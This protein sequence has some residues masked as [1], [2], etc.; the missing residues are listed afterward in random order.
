MTDYIIGA[1]FNISDVNLNGTRPTPD[2][3]ENEDCLFLD[4]YVPKKVFNAACNGRER[5]K[6]KPVLVWIYGGGYTSGSKNLNPSGLIE[7][8]DDGILFVAMNYRLGA[9]GFMAGPTFQ[10]GGTANAGL[11]DQR[12]ALEWVQKNIH[13]FGGDKTK[14]TVLG[15][16]AGGGSRKSLWRFRRNASADFAQSFIRSR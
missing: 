3:R 9:L 7:R 14:V 12:F 8:S 4:V 1:N 11:Y 2:P 13:L 10:Q 16:S 6:L 5:A 15:E